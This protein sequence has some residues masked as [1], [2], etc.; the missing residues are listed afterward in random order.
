L[1]LIIYDFEVFKYDWLVVF[2]N[3]ETRERTLIINNQEELNKFYNKHKEDIFVGYNSRGYDQ[4]IIKAILYG[5]DPYYVT[6]QIINKNKKGYKIIKNMDEYSINNFDIATGFHSLKQLEGF[7][8]SRIKETD[9]P[10]DIDRPLTKDELKQV[11]EYC[12]HDVEESS[13]VLS[14][15]YEEF[16]SQLSLIKAFDLP[17]S[18]FNKTKAQLSAHVL[19]AVRQDKLDDEFNL[20]FPDTLVVSDKYKHIVEWY[21]NPMNMS[22]SR[23]LITDVSGVPHVFAWGGIHGAIPNYN[24]EGIILCADVA[25]L[26]PTLMI[27]Y[28]YISR[29]VTDPDKL[30]EIRDTRL[31]LKAEKNP[32]Q[33]PLK[34]VINANYG[35][36]KDQYNPL[37]DPLMAN[38]VCI[39]GQLLLLDL[40]DKLE[41]YGTLIQSNTDGIFM[42]IKDMETVELI[43]NVA[44][45]WERRTRLDLEWEI[46][47]KIYQKDVNNYIIIDKNGKYKSKGGYVKKLSNIDY[48]LPIINKALVN[49]FVNGKPIEN[50]INECED[51]REYQKI[52]K[53]SSLYN[54]AVHNDNKLPEKVLRVFASK[55]ENDGSIY[56]IKGKDKFEKI[57]NTPDNCFVFNE[58]VTDV[59]IP[60]KLNKEYYI[61]LAN[62]R[63]DDF[64]NEKEKLTK[65]EKIEKLKLKMLHSTAGLDS[66]YDVLIVNKN[67]KICT[68]GELE[69]LIKLDTFVKYGM[70]K[71]LLS[72][73]DY[74]NLIYNKKSPK[75][76]TIRDKINDEMILNLLELNSTPTESAYSKLDFERVLRDIYDLLPNEDIFYVDKIKVQLEFEN[77]IRY[78][79]ENIPI[80]HLYVVNANTVNNTLITAYCMQNGLSKRLIIPKDSF[81]ILECQIGDV[82]KSKKYEVRNAKKLIG[83]DTDGMNLF[84]DD[85]NT[86]EYL[87]K[88]YEI[89]HR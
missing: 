87:L 16:E 26:Y 76:K 77:N 62:K 86:V 21:Q 22:Y 5:I 85:P 49:Y 32:M 14:N 30:R 72:Y 70:S 19:G 39:A 2:I 33:L 68:N 18:M 15:R 47:D 31:K 63:L 57:A 17:M 1:K 54:Y 45:E 46:F 53:V 42:K 12:T 59:K 84:G 10:F 48:D 40:I 34:I 89:I 50:T 7:M 38:N 60:T 78:V 35:A 67:E 73:L 81:R 3:H 41:S 55:D 44:K 74:F 4:F 80:E 8:G 75:K 43:K 37:Y 11:S 82:I 56:K 36:M 13:K 69:I 88:S 66:F 20:S 27:E 6:D 61:E 29:N 58:K 65:E 25:S 79:N 71:K 51:L 83:K 52:V 64:L 23:S 9:V 28:G 24:D